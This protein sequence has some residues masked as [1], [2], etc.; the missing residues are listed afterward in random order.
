MTY[1]QI[2]EQFRRATGVRYTDVKDYKPYPEIPYA[3]KV[4]LK[5][6]S[7]I[8][9]KA[10]LPPKVKLELTEAEFEVIVSQL[11]TMSCIVRD[12]SLNYQEYCNGLCAMGCDRPDLRD[13]EGWLRSKI[14]KEEKN[15]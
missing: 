12:S 6:G 4:W 9:Y 2:Y 15:E 8:I 5:N 14:I 1:G 3:I 7:E 13:V 11:S 10:S